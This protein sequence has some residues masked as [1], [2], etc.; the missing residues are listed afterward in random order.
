MITDA[1]IGSWIK[2]EPYK[3]ENDKKTIKR[4]TEICPVTFS[5]IIPSEPISTTTAVMKEGRLVDLVVPSRVK[6]DKNEKKQIISPPKEYKPS[7]I[8]EEYSEYNGTI[9]KVSDFICG[10]YSLGSEGIDKSLKEIFQDAKN[11]CYQNTGKDKKCC[12]E[13]A[14]KV[15]ESL[16]R[17]AS[18]KIFSNSSQALLEILSNSYDAMFP[19]KKVGK[20]GMG[21]YS[22]FDYIHR[23]NKPM[24]LISYCKQSGGNVKDP[25]K[26]VYVAKYF[27]KDNELYFEFSVFDS[28]VEKTGVTFFIP[29]NPETRIF[30]TAGMI[31]NEEF[32]KR[33]FYGL[34]SGT[35]QG[36]KGD[37]IC[38][39]DYETGI[40]FEVFFFNL[41][42]PSSSTKTL[43]KAIKDQDYK[44]EYGYGPD[45][46][47]CVGDI[48][49]LHLISETRSVIIKLP[50][51]IPL[52]VSRDEILL[53]E[54]NAEIFSAALLEAVNGLEKKEE[55]YF[56]N[57][58][59]NYKNTTLLNTNKKAITDF[60]DKYYE[61]RETI[62][63]YDLYFK[64]MR[65]GKHDLM[66]FSKHFTPGN[67]RK[68]CEKELRKYLMQNYP[69]KCMLIDKDDQNSTLI[70][71]LEEPIPKNYGYNNIVFYESKTIDFVLKSDLPEGTTL[72][73][74]L[75]DVVKKQLEKI[76]SSTDFSRFKYTIERYEKELDKKRYNYL[77]EKMF[78]FYSNYRYN[79]PY[80]A[81][82]YAA[83]SYLSLPTKGNEFYK[84][85]DYAYVQKDPDITFDIILPS[86][87]E[88]YND[89]SAEDIYNVMPRFTTSGNV[90]KNKEILLASLARRYNVDQRTVDFSRTY[91][92]MRTQRVL[93]YSTD[94]L[95][96][97]P[98]DFDEEK[99]KKLETRNDVKV[100]TSI[101]K[102]ISQ[103][104]VQKKN[105]TITTKE[106]MKFIE[107]SSTRKPTELQLV[108]IA[109]NYGTS[110]DYMKSL[111]S[112]TIQNAIDVTR[113]R[114]KVK[115]IFEHG[116]YV[117]GHWGAGDN[118]IAK[119]IPG[120]FVE[121]KQIYT[122]RDESEFSG[123][124]PDRFLSLSIP[125]YSSKKSGEQQTT[126][127]IGSGFFNVYK[128]AEK[129]MIDSYYREDGIM[130]NLICLD[131]PIRDGE[132]VV[133]IKRTITIQKS[134]EGKEPGT[135]LRVYRLSEKTD[136]VDIADTNLFYNFCKSAIELEDN[137]K[138]FSNKYL[139]VYFTE[140]REVGG[141]LLNGIP[142]STFSEVSSVMNKESNCANAGGFFVSIKKPYYKTSQTRSS[143]EIT[144]K[145]AR[146]SLKSIIRYCNVLLSHPSINENP[147]SK[148]ANFDSM[149]LY[150]QILPESYKKIP[151]INRLLYDTAEETI[152]G[153]V[154][155]ISKNIDATDYFYELFRRAVKSYV[156]KKSFEDIKKMKQGGA[157]K[158]EKEQ[159][160]HSF[161]KH[162][163]NIIKA[164]LK[165]YHK[166]GV[167][168]G[169]WKDKMP[170]LTFEYT[171]LEAGQYMRSTNT[172]NMNP[173]EVLE[174]I[175]S[176]T[177]KSYQG[178]IK[179]L[180]N[181]TFEKNPAWELFT[182]NTIK[183]P[184]ILHEMEHYRTTDHNSGHD[185]RDL[186]VK[187]T[188]Y[189]QLSYDEAC[190]YT[191]KVLYKD[192][193][194]KEFIK[195]LTV[196][197][198]K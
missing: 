107:N 126:G 94:F 75:L 35:S 181:G 112:E 37:Y 127:E 180:K 178:L 9:F 25:E 2:D 156:I 90:E 84:L 66:K 108:E 86:F 184:T 151:G 194:I 136:D 6:K 104:F 63:P 124:S 33:T 190:I 183:A 195:E 146:E 192:S 27:L 22:I 125:F 179:D 14:S 60:E 85:I 175:G 67:P 53:D 196:L 169:L 57:A 142:F 188:L 23:T 148:I 105:P 76:K 30:N 39:C 173:K 65:E 1:N 131:E 72:E 52:P 102:I 74:R 17:G 78:S 8:V 34:A 139:D 115:M 154:N 160:K 166:R 193:F 24:Y 62:I 130:Y 172:L 120:T 81:S 18:R 5:S 113:D 144:S 10:L 19:D 3:L 77:I 153:I 95:E 176:F 114:K 96:E 89:M 50:L 174:T 145:E 186:K 41:M 45:I 143:I 80:G 137:T 198:D 162:N 58:L 91:I 128:K 29:E 157:S 71:H 158:K 135:I 38:F 28:M 134:L 171:E 20:F 47:I 177:K 161:P 159:F 26:Y 122:I 82:P 164:F 187:G 168:E 170:K 149:S 55:I 119:Y 129:V 92:I 13:I 70:F 16:V 93:V 4:F 165:V 147:I 12:E 99:F 111:L 7:K 197:S 123:L 31:I 88:V 42:V 116:K 79:V 163:A 44:I 182:I 185:R 133:D 46:T 61:Q 101:K 54:K 100:E 106:F 103:T 69:E 189:K 109:S 21:F 15:T 97:E 83:V 132:N 51:T 98:M 140:K 141:W 110:K 59:N 121:G 49:I 68:S 117:Q 155:Q 87:T 167:E 40:P 32:R 138:I 11:K 150:S 36:P 48:P 64:F 73:G 118:G 191:A 43:K 152:E 56:L